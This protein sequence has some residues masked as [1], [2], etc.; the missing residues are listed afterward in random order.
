[1]AAEKDE[2]RA[3]VRSNEKKKKAK[4]PREKGR[5]GFANDGAKRKAPRSMKASF[6]PAARGQ[7]LFRYRG[8]G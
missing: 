8:N 7:H 1:M 4:A 6:C 2:V 3:K 5:I